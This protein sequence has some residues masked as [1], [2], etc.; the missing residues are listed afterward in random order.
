MNA[1]DAKELLKK[2]NQL[3][4]QLSQTAS[5]FVQ[6]L[7]G[8]QADV[9][10]DWPEFF[11]R[12]RATNEKVINK[13]DNLFHQDLEEERA[14]LEAMRNSITGNTPAAEFWRDMLTRDIDSAGR[15]L[16]SRN[17]ASADNALL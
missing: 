7:T 10:N 3:L 15:L 11:S 8:D 2:E 5:S 13:A 12:W 4:V 9:L 17:P 6:N 1:A 14:F 16:F